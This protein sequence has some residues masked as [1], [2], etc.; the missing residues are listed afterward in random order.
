LLQ[1]RKHFNDN[2]LKNDAKKKRVL[3]ASLKAVDQVG[4]PNA[5]GRSRSFVAEI[6]RPLLPFFGLKPKIESFSICR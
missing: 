2:D 3:L 5:M 6:P 1:E 4:V